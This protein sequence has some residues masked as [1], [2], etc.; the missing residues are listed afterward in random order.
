MHT[1]VIRALFWFIGDTPGDPDMRRLNLHVAQGDAFPYLSTLA[2][3]LTE[4]PDQKT[5]DAL[6]KE[7]RGALIHLH[8]QYALIPSAKPVTYAK[9]PIIRF[10]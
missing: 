8:E 1:Y 6:S 4:A 7:L 3:F 10:K 9:G 5:R 2:G